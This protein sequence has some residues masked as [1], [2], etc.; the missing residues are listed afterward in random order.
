MSRSLARR[1][2]TLRIEAQKTLTDAEAARIGSVTK[3]KRIEAG[4]VGVKLATV[5]HMCQ[6][7]G[8][9]PI[10]TAR[11]KQMAIAAESEAAW[12]EAYSKLLPPLFCRYLDL[13]SVA[14]R[15]YTF[16]P[17]VV[18]DLLQ[19]PAY[20]QAQIVGD[21]N[22]IGDEVEQWGDLRADR[23][24]AAFE[25]SAPPRV[26]AVVGEAALHQL[27]GGEWTMLEQQRHLLELD[28]G[29]HIEVRVLPFTAGAHAG[30][31]GQFS[32]LEFED[33]EEPNVVY[34]DGYLGGH[35]SSRD[36]VASEFRTRFDLI[37]AASVPAADLLA[38]TVSRA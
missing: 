3:I 1:L 30:S 38:R 28:S 12:W 7:Y 9:D 24:R 19:I 8:A 17:D 20:Q 31:K 22:V 32:I 13:E 35:Y 23:Q 16:H 14:D 11:L 33:A 26:V 10:T 5:I 6:V 15:I 21:P 2:K 27:V 36:S 37:Y 34:A 4:S 18:P 29:P 25:R